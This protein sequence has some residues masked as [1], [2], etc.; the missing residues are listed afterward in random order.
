[1]NVNI[2]PKKIYKI[3]RDSG[4]PRKEDIIRC[5]EMMAWEAEEL[6]ATWE[7]I[8]KVSLKKGKITQKEKEKLLSSNLFS[9]NTPLYGRLLH[10]YRNI[11]TELGSKK[12]YDWIEKIY[13]RVAKVIL[14]KSDISKSLDNFNKTKLSQFPLYLSSENNGREIQDLESSLQVLQN[15]VSTLK[16]LPE[17]LKLVDIS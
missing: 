17:T 3:I 12:S 1:M 8:I 9:E 11:S 2:E 5:V 16:S 4:K 7:K 14:Y 6:C 13:N 15:E 10:F